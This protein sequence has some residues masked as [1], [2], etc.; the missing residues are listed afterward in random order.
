M[1]SREIE[2][3]KI[4]LAAGVEIDDAGCKAAL[5]QQ[6]ARCATRSSARSAW[7]SITAPPEGDWYDIPYR[8]LVP[9]AID[10]L[11]VSGR[12]ISATHEGMAGARV[13]GTCVAIGQAAG[14][15]AAVAARTAATPRNLDVAELRRM[16]VADAALL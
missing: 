9:R 8:C 13:T 14:T 1:I 10:N 16:L 7:G 12:C 11:L 3:Q 2:G 5:F 15:A 4:V 6:G